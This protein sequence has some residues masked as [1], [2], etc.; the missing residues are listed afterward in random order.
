[1]PVN[2]NAFLRF[3]IIDSLL[4]SGGMYSKVEILEKLKEE[5]GKSISVETFNLDLRVLRENFQAPIE[6]KQREGYYYTD[7][8]YRLAKH[9]WT[10]EE[11]AAF[12]FAYE[13]LNTLSHLDL[14][15]EA[16]AVLLN[17]SGRMRKRKDETGKRIIYKPESPP[18]KGVEWL[19]VLYDAI[20]KE[21]TLTIKYY[22]L[23]TRETKTHT[24]SP[25]ILRQYNDLWY[26]VGW[27]AGRELTLVFAL[28]R[29]RDVRPANVSYYEDPRFDA[30]QYFQYSFGITHSYYD[31]PQLVK[32]WVT[33]EAFYYMQARPMHHSQKV[34]KET[35]TRIM[36]QL[37]VIISE[38]L[39]MALRG[40]G[41]RVKVI[42]PKEL[43][44]R[45]SSK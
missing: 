20:D 5:L 10:K 30:D 13:A 32:L 29:I 11:L 42:G 17:L 37:E 3:K 16:Q 26:V 44:N 28:D 8:S 35:A 38:E 6:F 12:E 1:M 45:I 2:K 23:Q 15:Q 4:A 33:R 31:K 40:L 21:Q 36:I 34:L 18:I 22:K 27:C 39:V 43:V 19:P 14:A 24:I 7:N 41:K 9:S 25:Y